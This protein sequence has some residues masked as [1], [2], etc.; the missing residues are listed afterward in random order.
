MFCVSIAF[1]AEG[2]LKYGVIYDPLREELFEAVQG[3]GAT[4]NGRPIRV[5][6]TE[7]LERAL[8]ATG[9]PYDIRERIPETLARLGRMLGIAQGVRRAGSAALD[10]AYVACGRFDGFWEEHLKPWDTAAGC[11]LIEEAGGRITTFSGGNYDIDAPN[12]VA[13]NGTLHD[14]LL[15]CLK[16]QDSQSH[17]PS[18]VLEKPFYVG[19][20]ACKGG[21]FAIALTKDGQWQTGVCQDIGA[22]WKKYH[23]AD[24]ILVDVPIGLRE[25]GADE[26]RV[27]KEARRKLGSARGPSVFRVPCRQAVYK[28]NYE[29]AKVENLRVTGKSLPVFTWG[30]VPKIRDVDALLLIDA[31][32]REHIKEIHPELCFW[33]L[34]GRPMAQKKDTELG[35]CERLQILQSNYLQTEAIVE[36]ALN[37]YPRKLVAKDDV[38]DALVA[39]I[40]ALGP[41][42]SLPDS[43]EFDNQGL[44]MQML[45]RSPCGDENPD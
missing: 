37:D 2:V 30:I 9:F 5:S 42:K 16:P 25:S 19:A 14:R 45:Y 31:R 27:D 34:A 15:A 29:D 6:T 4:L 21:W 7:R 35:F 23:N 3:Q 11:L 38:L 12:I 43:P 24:L 26:R 33:A 32:A 10:M 40:T 22:L 44:P 36:H 1:E 13:S 20:D 41:L 8:L 28:N 18:R 17:E 39:A